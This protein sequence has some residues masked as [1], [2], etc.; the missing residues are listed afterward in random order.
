M[1]VCQLV[2]DEYKQQQFRLGERIVSQTFPELEL[3]LNDVSPR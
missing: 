1:T 3:R 2:D